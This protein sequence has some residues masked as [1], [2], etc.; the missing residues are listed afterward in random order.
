MAF[1][2]FA[3]LA[4]GYGA[5]QGQGVEEDAIPLLVAILHSL[6]LQAVGH[7][8][9]VHSNLLDTHR[10]VP[11][12]IE[13][14]HVG[15]QSRG[16][17]DVG[18]GFV[19]FDVLLAHAESHTESG[20]AL[21][22]DR[23][24]DDATWES[25]LKHLG[26]GKETCG[27]AT[28]SHRDTETLCTAKGTVGTHLARG[29]QDGQRHE[30]GSHTNK[31]TQL[32]ALGDKGRPILCLAKLVGVLHKSSKVGAIQ[33]HLVSLARNDLDATGGSVG[34]HHGKRL[35]QDAL[36]DEHLAHVVLHSLA[37]TRVEEHNHRLASRGGL[38]EQRCI[39]Q[40][41]ASHAS[42]H[43]LIVHQGFQSSLTNLGLVGRVAGVPTWI[44]EHIAHDDG[45]GDGAVVSHA[46]IGAEEFVLPSQSTAMVKELVLVDAIGQ[47]QRFAWADVRR[48]SL[49][50]Q[51]LH[52]AYADGLQ[53]FL[54]IGLVRDTIVAGC[55]VIGNHMY[56]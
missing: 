51:L 10:T 6:L 55:K 54:H 28:V 24:T 56:L 38:V 20:V 42:H 13:A 36:V 2:H 11:C 53:H 43:S 29:L 48:Y 18:G 22:I 23:P 12:G 49:I 44:F 47:R 7:A 34:L 25:A 19:A 9:D 27:R 35:R 1:G 8:E 14:T 37:R 17:A 46:D 26:K 3:H 4:G 15:H 52:R 32:V 33:L 21:G 45:R 50:N 30:V 5:L 16:G 40:R 31:N 41:Q 39:A